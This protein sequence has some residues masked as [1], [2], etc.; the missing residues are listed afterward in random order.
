L[1]FCVIP[2]GRMALILTEYEK[3]NG[4]VEQSQ[5]T[6]MRFW[7]HERRVESKSGKVVLRDTLEFQPVIGDFIIASLIKLLFES[8]HSRLRKKY[9]GAAI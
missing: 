9:G 5:V 6:M 4:F 1:L 7:R 3:Y 2:I 8:R